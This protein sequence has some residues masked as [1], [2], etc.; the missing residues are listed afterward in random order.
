MRAQINIVKVVFLYDVALTNLI[1]ITQS[2]N[3]LANT[4][5]AVPHN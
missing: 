2:A 1:N 5:T 3:E 4:D